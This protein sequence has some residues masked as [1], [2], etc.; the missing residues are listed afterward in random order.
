MENF[1]YM[2]SFITLVLDPE[3]I[4]LAA[5]LSGTKE[6]MDLTVILATALFAIVGID[7]IS[8]LRGEFGTSAT[9][10]SSV[11][12]IV[13]E[14]PFLQFF[15]HQLFAGIHADNAFLKGAEEIGHLRFFLYNLLATT[16]LLT[17][18]MVIG[19]VIR[20]VWIELFGHFGP[21]EFEFI[22]ALMVAYLL[23][24]GAKVLK[25]DKSEAE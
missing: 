15:K 25:N 12:T 23:F 4:K 7:Q 14:K 6:Y 5:V 1:I 9:T 13:Q 3:G 10:T 2:T 18:L 19:S 17:M 8:L 16:A 11:N 22:S 21:F 20:M 24:V